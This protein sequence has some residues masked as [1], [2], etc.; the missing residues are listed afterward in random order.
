MVEGMKALPEPLNTLMTGQD[1]QSRLFRQDLRRWNSPSPFTFIR[2]NADD[3]TS[4]I[5]EAFQV[6]QIHG[7]VY[8]PEG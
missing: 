4:L 1:S 6:F 3:R 7:T 2:S 8:H 5:V